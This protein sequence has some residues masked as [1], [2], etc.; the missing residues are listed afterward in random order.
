MIQHPQ[1]F[2][3]PLQ[4]K[5][6]HAQI[7]EAILKIPKVLEENQRL[8]IWLS[9]LQNIQLTAPREFLLQNKCQLVRFNGLEA[10]ISIPTEGCGTQ[11]QKKSSSIEAAFRRVLGDPVKIRFE[12]Q[13]S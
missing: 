4:Q 10:T 3:T 5:D 8:K 11:A 7:E 1:T 13:D 9:V 2:A 12:I 6:D